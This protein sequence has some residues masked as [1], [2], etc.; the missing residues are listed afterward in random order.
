MKVS[1]LA[2]GSKG[3]STYLETTSHKILIDIGT[4]CKYIE[5]ELLDIDVL[6]SSIDTIFI[7]HDHIDHISALK[8]FLKKNHP[9]VYVTKKIKEE[10]EKKIILEKYQIINNKLLLDELTVDILKTSHDAIDSV[11]FIFETEFSSLV[12]ITDTGY[13][14]VKYFERLKNKKMYILESNHDVEML[15]NSKYRYDL[16]VRILGD[17]GHL[18]NEMATNYLK[19][20]IGQKT[21]Y[22]ILIHLSE[23]NNTE[24]IAYSTLEKKLKEEHIENKKIIIAKQNERTD[25]IEV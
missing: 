19:E 9:T 20:F 11:G 1:V 12:Y 25:L 7:T 2:S 15:M 16:K 14:N 5:K 13:I 8:V 23:E 24:E 10:I 4:N 6:P 21:E 17:R 22:I 3:N 18:S